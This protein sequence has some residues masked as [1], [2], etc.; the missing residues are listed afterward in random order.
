MTAL[1]DCPTC[2][3][4]LPA[5]RRCC[6]HCHCSSPAWK[7]WALAATAAASLG[8]ADCDGT[9]LHHPGTAD[10]GVDLAAPDLSQPEP[11][12]EYGPA[13]IFDLAEP[14]DGGSQ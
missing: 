1:L 5:G 9:G 8:A 13:I 4:L 2:G 11:V 6:P 14:A 7:R 3:G 12:V 10:A